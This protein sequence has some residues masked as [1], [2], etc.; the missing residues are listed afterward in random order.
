[1]QKKYQRHDLAV[2]NDIYGY[3][4]CV[5]YANH[6]NLWHTNKSS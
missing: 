1:M 4:P 2:L 6:E 5:D 3:H